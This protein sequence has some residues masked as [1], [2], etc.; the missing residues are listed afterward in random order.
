LRNVV[1]AKICGIAREEDLATALEAGADAVG[2]VVGVPTSPRNISLKKAEE[3]VGKVPPFTKSV[4]VMVPD[5]LKELAEAHE[6][7]GP[8]ALQI[9]GDNLPDAD[10]I[11]AEIRG[12]SLI[13]AINPEPGEALEAA[14]AT[15]GFDAILL[16]TFVPGMHGGTGVT[17]DWSMSRK[18]RQAIHPRKL[19]LAG[20][21]KPSNVQEAILAVKP[22]AVDVSTGVESSP[23]I[24]DPEKIISFIDR[25]REVER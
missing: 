24:K 2:F 13:R 6:M 10:S 22:Y 14:E 15:A 20:G 9:H 21:L 19:I 17:Q 1:K 18:I 16:D 12:A 7:V 5:S 3:L 11:R 23:G 8:D 4:L 25:V